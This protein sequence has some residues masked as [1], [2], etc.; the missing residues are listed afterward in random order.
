VRPRH[1]HI[2]GRPLLTVTGAVA[3]AVLHRCCTVMTSF[4]CVVEVVE[5]ALEAAVEVVQRQDIR[6]VWAVVCSLTA[7]LMTIVTYHRRTPVA[8][9]R[10]AEVDPS[11]SCR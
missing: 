4:R 9:Y 6:M 2:H 7:N 1:R 10:V 3:A 5:E 11:R 8:H